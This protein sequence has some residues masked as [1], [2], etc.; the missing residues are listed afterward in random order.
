MKKQYTSMGGGMPANQ[1]PNPPTN[2][3]TSSMVIVPSSDFRTLNVLSLNGNTWSEYKV[4][5][6]LDSFP[7]M[8]R[9]SLLAVAYSGENIREVA[10]FNGGLA[11]QDKWSRQALREPVSDELV[12]IVAE[13]GAYYVVGR[14]VYAYSALAT[15][16]GVLN[17]PGPTRRPAT[18][19]A[20]R[21][22]RPLTEQVTPTPSSPSRGGRST[23]STSTVASGVN[24]AE[25]EQVKPVTK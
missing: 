15:R 21:S 8:S 22:I 25:G 18:S 13:G 1:K 23:S 11:N 19:V 14:D 9:G 10:V 20:M 12:P 5:E 16:W 3:Q 6:G 7:V 17:L 4:P 24:P 2:Y